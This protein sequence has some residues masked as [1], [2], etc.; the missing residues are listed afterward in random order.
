MSK[1]KIILHDET[2]RGHK[3]THKKSGMYYYW[4]GWKNYGEEEAEFH[5][6]YSAKCFLLSHSSFPKF[7]TYL[8]SQ[9]TESILDK[10]I[11]KGNYTFK[12]FESNLLCEFVIVEVPDV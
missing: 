10:M 12:G 11:A 1:Y 5:S 6:T 8:V 2:L 3:Q 7:A 9:P 4:H